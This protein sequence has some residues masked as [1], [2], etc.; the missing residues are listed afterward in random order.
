[1][2]KLLILSVAFIVLLSGCT[3]DLNDYRVVSNYESEA[4]DYD[5][6]VLVT[7]NFE[8]K[9]SSLFSGE[10]TR[11]V[12]NLIN[13]ASIDVENV[14]VKVVN[15]DDLNPTADYTY[16][17]V[18]E[19]NHS[20]KFEWDLTAPSLATG[21]TLIL[22][23][24]FVRAYFDAYAKTSKAIMLKEPGDRAYTSTF[25][26]ST[27]SPLSLY[28]DTSYETVTTLNDTVKNFTVNLVYFNNYTGLV[29]YYDNTEIDD[30]YLERLIIGIDKKLTFYNYMDDNTPWMKINESF[31][32]EELSEYGLASTDLETKNYY[33]VEFLTLQSQGYNLCDLTGNL[34]QQLKE[35]ESSLTEQRRLLWMG[36][37]FTKHNILR[38]GAPSVE[39][40]TEVMLTARAE[41]SYSQDFGGEDF[42]VIIYGLG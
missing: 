38:L 15:A 22:N 1:M 13:L 36:S 6:D 30:N 10:M 37:G 12:L 24:I 20:E 2:K 27:E 32:E 23:N 21:E 33:Y 8:I 29:D 9:R 25:S 39:S 19:S 26:Q 34:T 14:H 17:E 4:D 35:L 11:L 40:D 28:Y 5:L 31:T 3:Q 18:I 7:D 41:Y 16:M 42:G